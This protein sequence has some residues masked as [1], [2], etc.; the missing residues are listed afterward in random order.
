M[1]T[2]VLVP[3]AGGQAWYWHRVV[4]ELQARGHEAIAVDLPAADDGAGFIEYADAVVAAIAPN[5]Q[6]YLVEPLP[7]AAIFHGRQAA[8]DKPRE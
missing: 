7:A 2:F 4:P 6:R 3:G 8:R 5:L 1:T